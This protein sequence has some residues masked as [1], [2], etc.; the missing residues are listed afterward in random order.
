M[1]VDFPMDSDIVEAACDVLKAGYTESTPGPFVLPL[2]VTVDF[3]TRS[4]IGTP[5]VD[6]VMGTASA[7]L[8]SHASHPGAIT[9]DAVRLILH[10]FDIFC[11]MTEFPQY[12]DPEISYSG[13]DFLTRLLPKYA[14]V[15]FGLAGSHRGGNAEL[16]RPPVLILPT[17][18]NYTLIALQGADPLPLRS[19]SSFWTTM[20]NLPSSDSSGAQPNSSEDPAQAIINDYIPSLATILIRQI[21]GSCAR[22]DLDHLC[23]V[24]KKLIFKH[25]G[26]ART[27]LGHALAN[28]D[29]AD[30]SAP[31]GAE[32][33]GPGP[34]LVSVQERERFL[35]SAIGLRGARATN[36]V[37]R[38]F[39][40]S[41]RGKVFA[42]TG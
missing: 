36:Q 39:W 22:S 20:L 30:A 25:Q 3:V 10:V 35:A 40:L 38:T 33:G 4:H 37:V 9:N 23:E 41:C 15:L 28:L 34:A 12:Y 7:F 31:D 5:R 26:A 11:F 8:D 32:N 13:I 42:Y 21:A 16:G 2:S 27:H 29:A 14:T 6:A 24:L 19:A 1:T 18:L 17:L